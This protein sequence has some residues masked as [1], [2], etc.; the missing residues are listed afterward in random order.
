MTGGALENPDLAPVRPERRT[1][2]VGSYAALWISMS[3]CVPTYMLASS[4]VGGGMNWWEAILTIFLGNAI[5][6]VPIL[7]NAH[8]GTRYGIPF[9][10]LCRASFGTRG[11]NIPALLR[12]FVACGWFGIQTWIGGDAI[13][14]ILGVFLPSF[15]AA[16]HNSL[17]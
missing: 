5:V 4:L 17:G 10:V 7:L 12:A 11:A 16:A 13:C 2:R 14:R 6:L 1:W 3:A 9:P 15:A 8:A